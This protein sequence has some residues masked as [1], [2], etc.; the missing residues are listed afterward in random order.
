M[1]PITC[2]VYESFL[3][4]LTAHYVEWRGVNITAAVL[5]YHDEVST[6]AGDS[7]LSCL[8]RN[9][10]SWYFPNG[11]I[12]DTFGRMDR[13]FGQLVSVLLLR[14]PNANVGAPTGNDSSNGLWTCRLNGDENGAIPIGLYHRG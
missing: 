4:L 2:M 11:T 12:V 14:N 9:Q 3:L 13:Y 8:E 10:A 5:I 7:P 1:I 6:I